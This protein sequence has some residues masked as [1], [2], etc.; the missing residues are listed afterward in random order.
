M[1]ASPILASALAL[2]CCT[3][4]LHAQAE[5]VS[6]AFSDGRYDLALEAADGLSDPVLAAEWRFQ[7]LHAAGDLPGALSAARAGLT[8]APTNSRLSQ[9]AANVAL[10]LQEGSLAL[11]FCDAW[12]RALDARVSDAGADAESRSAEVERLERYRASARELL[13]LDA[14]A[15][16][17]TTRARNVALALLGVTVLALLALARGARAATL[18]A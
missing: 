11:E 18:R 9:N 17:A 16:A 15:R 2:A 3:S 7:V 14:Q 5:G 4:A 8:L 12:Q 1:R 13:A 6:E 10:A